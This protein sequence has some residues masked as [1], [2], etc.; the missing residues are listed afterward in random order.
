M[1][2]RT[3]LSPYLLYISVFNVRVE[4]IAIDSGSG[5]IYYTGIN[6]GTNHGFIG[7]VSPS[8]DQMTL[9]EDLIQP[10]DI[11]LHGEDG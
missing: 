11:V 7:V 8:G 10:I 1:S 3:E 9:I 2:K 6:S 5:N 4:R